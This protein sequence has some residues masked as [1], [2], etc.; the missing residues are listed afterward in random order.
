MKVPTKKEDFQLPAVARA[1]ISS[2]EGAAL[3][4]LPEGQSAASTVSMKPGCFRT[5]LATTQAATRQSR[6]GSSLVG[7]QQQSKKKGVACRDISCMICWLQLFADHVIFANCPLF[8]G[9]AVE[10]MTRM[11][12]RKKLSTAA[13]LFGLFGSCSSYGFYGGGFCAYTSRPLAVSQ[14]RRAFACALQHSF[15]CSVSTD[16]GLDHNACI[17]H[18]NP[19]FS[20]GGR[21]R[22]CLCRPRHWPVLPVQARWCHCAISHDFPRFV[23]K[24]ELFLL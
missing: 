15:F 17:C 24:H 14:M 9:P 11:E 22:S 7:Q 18:A 19:R 23:R 6:A 8:A 4:C 13:I 10:T 20:S 5:C 1:I 16:H 21:H 2:W 12:G 3:L